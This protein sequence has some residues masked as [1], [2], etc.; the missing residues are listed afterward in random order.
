[1]DTG[2]A[3]GQSCVDGVCEDS[4]ASCN[5]AIDLLSA[6]VVRNTRF[7]F[8]GNTAVNSGADHQ[9]TCAKTRASSDDHFSFVVPASGTWTI[10][11]TT[12][13]SMVLSRLASCPASA[14]P[15]SIDCAVVRNGRAELK[16]VS[17]EAG[18]EVFF[19]VDGIDN[20]LAPQNGEYL[21]EA[22]RTVR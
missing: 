4:S 3:R 13:K 2:C 16:L 12:N 20:R 5:G 1:G 9:A 22:I 7:R 8:T 11:L 19:L 18:T 15:Q 6:E 21:L 17:A 10:R 14:Q